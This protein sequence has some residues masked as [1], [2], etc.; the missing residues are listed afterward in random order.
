MEK[1]SL[2]KRYYE[3][4]NSICVSQYPVP[5]SCHTQEELP[6]LMLLDK[7]QE[8]IRKAVLYVHIPF[9]EKICSFC[10]F[11]KYQ[12]SRADVDR[13]LEA[14]MKEI[15]AYSSRRYSE[16]A[17]LQCVSFGGGTPTALA[18]G[19]LIE[20]INALKSAFRFSEN[21]MLFVEGNPRNFTLEK[22]KALQA[23]GLNR[24]SA[25]VQTFQPEMEKNLELFH[26]VQ[27]SRA[28]IRNAR[29][30]GIANI[31]IDLMYNL[32]GQ[33]MGDWKADIEQ[34]IAQQIDHICLL[35]F[36]VVPGTGISAKIN[37][38]VL[39]LI[40]DW[41]KEITFFTLARKRLLAAGYKQYTIVDFALP[42]K[43]DKYALYYFGR[44]ADLIG[45]GA[46][47]H[48]FI[49]G[50]MYVNKGTVDEYAASCC[51]GEFPV[52]CGEKAAGEELARGMMAR[53]MRML[54]VKRER[55]R[56]L[57]HGDF[58]DIF[59]RELSGLAR[60]GLITVDREGV[61]LTEDGIIWG[62]NVCREFFSEKY[63]NHELES[64][65]I[66]ARGRKI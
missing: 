54:S 47:A 15:H 9:C 58:E 10:P 13:Y 56:R 36:C 16:T 12:H 6:E 65:M 52:V 29:E 57:Q 39:P 59:S 43:I 3:E 53:G 40:G 50:Y 8:K 23:A 44:Q 45:L 55:F 37:R 22:L 35:A 24:I 19:E 61:H 27:D 62:N 14:L 30:A 17:V 20:I 32:P 11:N 66:L 42:G 31:G 33:E 41:E 49:N 2:F 63:K 46:A 18:A 60:Q 25:G 4:R 28:L 21:V 64:R 34:A 48:G 1:K 38:G 51:R 26:S 5:V 7:K